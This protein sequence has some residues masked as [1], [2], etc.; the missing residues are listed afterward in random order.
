MDT[1]FQYCDRPLHREHDMEWDMSPRLNHSTALVDTGHGLV[2][3]SLE[4]QGEVQGEVLG[5]A[6]GEA[7]GEARVHLP[8]PDLALHMG[9]YY[10]AG[11]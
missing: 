10:I 6:Q 3:W 11:S 5:E 2:M 4:V 8:V 1:H 9:Q 7:Q